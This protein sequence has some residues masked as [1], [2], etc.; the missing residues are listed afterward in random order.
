[1]IYRFSYTAG[2]K[3]RPKPT[4]PG[5]ADKMNW[6]SKYS[7][8]NCTKQ[9]NK[10][11]CAKTCGQCGGGSGGGS[12]GGTGGGSGGGSSKYLRNWL[13]HKVSIQKTNI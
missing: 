6:C 2:R 8:I 13:I 4:K 12:G 9:K 10:N 5:C 1:M 7:S 11:N 3:I